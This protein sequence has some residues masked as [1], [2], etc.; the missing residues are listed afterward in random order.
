MDRGQILEELEAQR[1][2]L[3]SAIAALQGNRRN[4][5]RGKVTATPTNGRKGR[6]MS[7]AAR[8]KISDAQKAR[9][10]KQKKAA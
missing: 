10:A 4:T 3:D 9:W 8:K 5:G 6:H 7:A 1:D 2:R